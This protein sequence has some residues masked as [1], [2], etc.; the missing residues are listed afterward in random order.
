MNYGHALLPPA[1][2]GSVIS[3]MLSWA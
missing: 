3:L 2:L 1:G